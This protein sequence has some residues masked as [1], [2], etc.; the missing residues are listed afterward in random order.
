MPQLALP[1]NADVFLLVVRFATFTLQLHACIQNGSS[2][3][4]FHTTLEQ[5]TDLEHDGVNTSEIDINVPGDYLFLHSIYNTRTGTSNA[6]REN[7]YLKW[8]VGGVDVD[9]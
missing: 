2:L 1:C 7:P 6:S 3:A 5:G 9:Y 4:F 8:Q